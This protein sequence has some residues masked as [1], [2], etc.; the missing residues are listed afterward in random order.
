MKKTLTNAMIWSNNPI[1]LREITHYV[2]SL[3]AGILAQK[4]YSVEGNFSIQ[5]ILKSL[6]LDFG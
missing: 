1:S 5:D 4:T 2:N 3:P 6:D